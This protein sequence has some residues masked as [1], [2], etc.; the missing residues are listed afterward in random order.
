VQ[1]KIYRPEV[2]NTMKFG[3]II[4]AM[5][6]L[7]LNGCVTIGKPIPKQ[8]AQDIKIGE[9]TKTDIEKKLGVPD[10][11]GLD[12]GQPTTTYLYYRVGFFIQPITTDLTIVFD[13]QGKVKSYVF[14]SNEN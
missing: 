1:N 6:I 4:M 12:S 14:N 9:T 7:L 11:L 10:R 13:E 8:L 3:L 2:N 5:A